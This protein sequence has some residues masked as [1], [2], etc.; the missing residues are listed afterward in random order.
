MLVAIVT[1]EISITD[2]CS[3]DLPHTLTIALEY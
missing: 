2:M 1:M 3:H